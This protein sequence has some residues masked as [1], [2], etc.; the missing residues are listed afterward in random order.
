MSKPLTKIDLK[1][2]AKYIVEET[3]KYKTVNGSTLYLS[4]E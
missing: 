2:L 1:L 4:F 3:K